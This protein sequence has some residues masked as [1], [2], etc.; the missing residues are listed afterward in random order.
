[1]GA[2]R[3]P[4][5]RADRPAPGLRADWPA[6]DMVVILCAGCPGW[7]RRGS[8][9]FAPTGPPSTW[10]STRPPIGTAVILRAAKRSRRIP[11][12]GSAS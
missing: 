6:I 10:P 4:G 9:A 3:Q 8:L 11:P 2:A 5:L 12:R 1:M 7:A